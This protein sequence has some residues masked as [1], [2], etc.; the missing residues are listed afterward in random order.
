M[1]PSQ[2][3]RASSSA[4]VTSYRTTKT[5]SSASSTTVASAPSQPGPRRR[6]SAASPRASRCRAAASAGSAPPSAPGPCC[7]HRPRRSPRLPSVRSQARPC[8]AAASR[9]RRPRS[10]T[11]GHRE[12]AAGEDRDHRWRARRIRGRPGRRPARRRGHGHRAG[13][14]GR[15]LRADRLRAVQD[16]DRHLRADGRA[17][18]RRPALGIQVGQRARSRGGR[19]RG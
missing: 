9:C 18:R 15:R 19:A 17:G 8:R 14:P 16:A 6:R 1:A 4:S 12:P 10:D 3:S 13:R 5:R 11:M 7:C 2:L